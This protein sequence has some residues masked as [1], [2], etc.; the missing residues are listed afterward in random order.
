M[1]VL[2][3]VLGPWSLVLL[4]WVLGPSPLGPWSFS[5]GSL[6]PGPSPVGPWSFP[7]VL[8]HW[9]SA[10][11]PSVLQVH[12][13]FSSPSALRAHGAILTPC[14]MTSKTAD[15][16]TLFLGVDICQTSSGI[17]SMMF[18]CLKGYAAYETS[19]FG[20]FW[21]ILFFTSLVPECRALGL[22]GCS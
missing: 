19:I 22:L 8:G 9:C 18:P 11:L 21:P 12:R 10:V 2:H 6:A 17:P 3:R 15:T 5:T 4:H 13:G 20:Y 1:A 16:C 7:R 14:H